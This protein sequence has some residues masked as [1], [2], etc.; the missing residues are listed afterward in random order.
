MALYHII[1]DSKNLRIYVYIEGDVCERYLRKDG[2][3]G[4][5][6]G[7]Y[8]GG[9]LWKI[10]G[11]MVSLGEKKVYIAMDVCGRYLGT[12]VSLGEKKVYIA[13]DVCGRYFRKDG[14][15]GGGEEGLYSHGCMVN[16]FYL[17]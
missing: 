15:V 1:A 11:R 9:C 12:M 17:K 7:L 16:I 10:L 14:F 4:R 2:F 6:E 8:R 3:G 13:M 5:E